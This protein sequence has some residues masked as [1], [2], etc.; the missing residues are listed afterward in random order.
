MLYYERTMYVYTMV[1]VLF[2][3]TGTTST[4]TVHTRGNGILRVLRSS[5]VRLERLSAM[6]TGTTS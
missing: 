1:I 3:Y 5:V 6:P 4:S 2:Y